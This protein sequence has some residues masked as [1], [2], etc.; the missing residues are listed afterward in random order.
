MDHRVNLGPILC[1]VHRVNRTKHRTTHGTITAMYAE[2]VII[3][4]I[5]INYFNNSNDNSIRASSTTIAG[6]MI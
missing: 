5:I 2:T 4:T 6:V 1:A 3:T